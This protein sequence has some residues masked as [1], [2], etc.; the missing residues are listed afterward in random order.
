MSLQDAPSLLDPLFSTAAMQAV[1][2]DRARLQ[3]MLD[4]EA[5]LA[6]AEAAVGVIPPAAAVAIAAQCRAALYSIGEL[7]T[8]TRL[9]GNPAIPLVKALTDRVARSD[10]TAARYVHWGASSQ[11]VIDTGLVLQLR[12]ALALLAGGLVELAAALAE[13][14]AAHRHTPLAARTLLQQAEPISFGL[15]AAGWLSAIERH[16]RRLQELRGRTQVLQFGGASGNLA[17]FGANGLDVAAALARDLSLVLPDLPWHTHR[18]RLAEVATTLGLL[19]GTLGKIARDLSLLMQTEVGEVAEPEAPGR[20]GSSALPHKHNPVGCG[21]VLAAALRAP[22]LVAT[23]LAAMLQEHERG[24]G[25]WHAEWE[26]LPQLCRLTAGALAHCQEV[27]GGLT[28][29]RARM[30]ANLTI[31]GGQ[32]HAAAVATALAASLGAPA[33]REL[34]EKLSSD[35]RTRGQ[36]LQAVLARDPQ[37]AAHLDTDALARLFAAAADAGLNDALIDRALA[38]RIT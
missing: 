27:V 25:G 11:D 13:L 20:G 23:M 7:A 36:S 5:A 31:T 33:A 32:I 22:G 3:A 14:A 4:Y 29:N 24:L 18:D 17:G 8:A 10:Q 35:A 9:A 2:C 28:V 12:T 38:A 26:T 30:A 19:L 34:V 21:A 16:R 37:V 15:K 1:F 6:R